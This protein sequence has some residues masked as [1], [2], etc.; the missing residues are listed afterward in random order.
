MATLTR[1][2]DTVRLELTPPEKFFALR[3]DV[4]VRAD[5]VV[6]A[7]AVE[8]PFSAVRGIR[9]PGL[10]WP[11]VVAIGRW[12]HRKGTDLVAIRRGEQAVQVD[13]DDTAPY[14]RLLIGVDDPAGVVRSLRG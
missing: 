13:L 1:S 7:T 9:A 12:R 8:R 10:G 11:R 2:G 5:Q 6:E 3:G 4:E 14:R